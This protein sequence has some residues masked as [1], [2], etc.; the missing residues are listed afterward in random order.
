MADE[1]KF[2]TYMYHQHKE[3]ILAISGSD[4]AP[5]P[6]LIGLT[7]S[8]IVGLGSCLGFGS[9]TRIEG[10]QE[11]ARGSTKKH[12]NPYARFNPAY[13]QRLELADP[14]RACC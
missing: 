2:T 6:A 5:R 7:L 12:Q 11:N 13:E 3:N 4:P 9:V 10:N 8:A 1:Q 14:A